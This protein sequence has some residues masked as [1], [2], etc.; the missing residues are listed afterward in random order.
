MGKFTISMA[1]FNSYV[2]LPEGNCI[3][4]S[5]RISVCFAG[6]VLTPFLSW[7]W[8]RWVLHESPNRT[9]RWGC[10]TSQKSSRKIAT[11]SMSYSRSHH[12]S[13]VFSLQKLGFPWHVSY[14]ITPVLPKSC[15]VKPKMIPNDP[16]WQV[17]WFS[18]WFLPHQP[19]CIA[20][21]VLT[22]NHPLLVPCFPCYGCM[23]IY[24][25]C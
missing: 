24:I 7:W 5:H 1:I 10:R 6:L 12:E 15:C 25:I 19:W 16:K 18:P 23:C 17:W 8:I 11:I 13:T 4:E 2:S 3:I 14:G 22:I 21:A 9:Q 20:N